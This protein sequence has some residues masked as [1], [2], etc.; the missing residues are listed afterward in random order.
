MAAEIEELVRRL[1]PIKGKFWVEQRLQEYS[2]GRF[3]IMLRKAIER[4]VKNLANYYNLQDQIILHPIPKRHQV[5]GKFPL[6][7]CHYGHMPLNAKFGLRDSDFI[8]HI[9]IFGATGSGKTTTALQIIKQLCEQ[10]NPFL[11]LD[12]KGTWQNLIKQTYAKDVKVLKLGSTYAPYTFD[13]FM[14]LPGMDID[15]LISDVVEVFCDSQYLGFGAKSLL[16]KAC[17]RARENNN[18]SISGVYEEFKRLPVAVQK[19]KSWFVSTHRALEAAATG[20][21][22]RIL[23]AADNIPFEKMMNSQV[24][25]LLDSLVDPDQVSIFNGLMLNRIYWYRKLAGIR[26]KFKHLLIF[27][28]FHVMSKAELAR[29][30]SRIDFLIKMCREFSQGVMVLEQNPGEI[31]QAVLG[32]LNTVISMNLGHQKDINAVGT[33]MVLDTYARKH[34]GRLPTGWAICRIKDRFPESVLVKVDHDLLDKT[35]LSE[36]KISAHN[37]GFVSKIDTAKPLSA[38]IKEPIV[39]R[40]KLNPLYRKILRYLKINHGS[41]L[42]NT[43]ISHGLGYRRGNYIKNKLEGMGLIFSKEFHTRTG[44]EIRIDLTDRGKRY[45]QNT[46]DSR[47][48][49]GH[50]HRSVVQQVAAYYKDMDYRVRLEYRDIDVFVDKGSEKVAIEVESLTGTKDVVHAV[51]NADKALKRADK[52]EIVVKNRQVAERLKKALK[53]SPLKGDRRIKIYQLDRYKL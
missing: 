37:R 25:V 28:E 51:Q 33:S 17:Y 42:K 1:E 9:G 39:G 6:G 36:K 41:N 48:L 45:L 13:P 14:P 7:Q 16:Q 29:G 47:R 40:D 38:G 8:K 52:L 30:E 2:D 22:G 50:W 24:I 26:E 19:E 35:E 44:K 11:I 23:N 43:Y 53:Q 31:S 49:G 5:N 18:L 15:T 32:N 21:L 20:I 12:P 34:L 27:E 4:E 3:N 46:E 10:K